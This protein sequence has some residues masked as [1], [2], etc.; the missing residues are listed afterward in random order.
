MSRLTERETAEIRRVKRAV[1]QGARD[2]ISQV[3]L[4]D[5]APSRQ[6]T[7]HADFAT[8][9]ARYSGL[10]EIGWVLR[11][12]IAAP[13]LHAIRVRRAIRDLESINDF[14]LRDIGIDRSRIEEIA[15]GMAAE[16]TPAMRPAFGPFAAVRRWLIQ[17]RTVNELSRLDDRVLADIGIVRSEIPSLVAR[18]NETQ[19]DGREGRIGSDQ[20]AARTKSPVGGSQQWN[21]SRQAANDMARLDPEN[22]ADLGYVK[23]DAGRV[24]EA[25]AERKLAVG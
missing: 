8:I 19:V 3:Y 24:P 16:P 23:G 4:A 7:P 25:P 5:G 10:A 18:L 22:L 20:A 9:V 21:L 15:R 17:R 14:L 6:S 2:E 13:V 11:H 12:K 1:Q